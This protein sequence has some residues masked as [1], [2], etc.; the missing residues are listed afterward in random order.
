MEMLREDP[1]GVKQL[2]KE[3][4]MEDIPEQGDQP[5]VKEKCITVHH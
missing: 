3:N 1:E 2:A 4:K 5:V